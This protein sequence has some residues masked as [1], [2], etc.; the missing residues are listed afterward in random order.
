M[1]AVRHGTLVA[2]QDVVIFTKLPPP[3]ILRSLRR[4]GRRLP[5]VYITA[6]R[7]SEMWRT[8]PPTRSLLD[9]FDAMIVQAP[10]FADELQSFGYRGRIE[11]IPYVP[12]QVTPVHDLPAPDGPM[13]LGFLGRLVPQKN[14]SY[15]LDA[16]VL[17]L[18]PQGRMKNPWELHLYGD[19]VE[20]A[21]LQAA[22]A[23]LGVR[24]RVH[25]H[26]AVAHDVVSAA[27]DGCHL[28]AF[29][30]L[31][32]GQCLAALEILARGRPIITAPVGAFPEILAVPGL[33]RIAPLHDP[34]AFAEA[35]AA[36]G[37]D[38]LSGR[39]TPDSVQARFGTL[40][41]HEDIVRRYDALL[42]SLTR[43]ATLGA[44]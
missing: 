5:F 14:V 44:A 10:S 15:L 26:G 43:T 18:P 12:P 6:Y 16:L 24:D 19:G 7:P 4:I 30:S 3:T 41:S 37:S 11:I 8:R 36:V 21:S 29:P 22:A 28:F 13:R 2:R 34:R 40:F 33:G 42:T 20:R 38:L 32:E 9:R 39:L 17:L 25:F 35:L 1:L 27:I 23:A 31:S